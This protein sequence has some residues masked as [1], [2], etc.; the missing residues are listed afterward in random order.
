MWIPCASVAWNY[1]A[2]L[3]SISMYG[4]C[5]PFPIIIK[6]IFPFKINDTINPISDIPINGDNSIHA[7]NFGR[8]FYFL[9]N[10]FFDEKTSFTTL[11]LKILVPFPS[12][13]ALN[14]KLLGNGISSH[15][16]LI[17]SGSSVDSMT[18]NAP[19]SN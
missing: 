8:R 16:C 1:F 7:S 6:F 18:F 4:I 2:Y 14:L 12:Y 5:E 13:R 15:S 11:I 17:L 3:L 10:F 9:Q 19:R